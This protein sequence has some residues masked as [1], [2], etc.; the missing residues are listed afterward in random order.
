[1]LGKRNR[2]A[3]RRGDPKESGRGC[4]P[5]PNEQ[6]YQDLL[7]GIGSRR[8]VIVRW[9]AWAQEALTRTERQS[10][11]PVACRRF[12]WS[13]AVSEA[14]RRPPPALLGGGCQE[15]HSDP[16]EKARSIILCV[17]LWP[18][19]GHLNTVSDLEA[20]DALYD[21]LGSD[22][23]YAHSVDGNPTDVQHGPSRL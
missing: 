5:G 16:K 20:P 22:V 7:G 11:T 8:T 3:L 1:M 10:S 23:V 9:L 21:S 17:C 12:R 2:V 15:P 14:K 6:R 19:P 13:C 18:S 4:A